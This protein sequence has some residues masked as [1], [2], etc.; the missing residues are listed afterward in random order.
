MRAYEG[1]TG[2]ARKKLFYF[3]NK[4]N[5]AGFTPTSEL[6]VALTIVAF[7]KDPSVC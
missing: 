2:L 3:Q 5:E 1:K 6:F 7:L 4:S